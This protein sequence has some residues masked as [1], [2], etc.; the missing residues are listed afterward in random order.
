MRESFVRDV[1]DTVAGLKVPWCVKIGAEN[2]FEPGKRCMEL[3][4]EAKDAYLRVCD[5]LDIS[6]DIDIGLP[7]EDVDLNTMMDHMEDICRLVG[8]EMFRCGVVFAEEYLQ[9]P[10]K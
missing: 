2:M 1:Y 3:Y 6:D 4:N 8:Y 7:P 5:R 10:E 9:L